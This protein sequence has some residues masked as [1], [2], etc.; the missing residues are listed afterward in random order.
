MEILE[1]FHLIHIVDNEDEVDAFYRELFAPEPFRPKHWMDRE[2]RWA[3]LSLVSDLV[4]EVIE[5]SAAEA[6]L[7]MPLSKFR[8][9]HG[10]HFHS[11]AWYVEPTSVRPLFE[12]LRQA[13]VRIAR[14]GGGVF[15]DGDIDPGNTIFTHPKDTFGQIEFEGRNEHWM[16]I[17]PR[18][19]PGWSTQ[20]WKE[21]PLGIERL[22][23]MT[24]VVR[25]LEAARRFYERTL[26]GTVFHHE[27]SATATSAFV[28]VGLDTVVELARANDETSRLAADLAAHGELPHSVTLLV[29]DL[30]NAER[31][32]EKVGVRVVDRAGDALLL[33][34]GDCFG[35]LWRFTDRR[36]PGDPRDRH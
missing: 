3:S 18:F 21:G 36:L 32:V 16:G 8:H 29:R 34:P 33:D 1:F 2:K 25:D 28:L 12:R 15:G 11:F 31:G 22:S 20:P 27:S 7:N 6:D 35:A 17:D 23:Y 5:P 4:L 19:K 14:P 10:Q 13:G 9:R 26:G 24:T 30:E